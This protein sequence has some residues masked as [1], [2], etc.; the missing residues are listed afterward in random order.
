MCYSNLFVSVDALERGSLDQQV[1]LSDP[2]VVANT[3]HSCFEAAGGASQG[4]VPC[5]AA[6]RALCTAH[7]MLLAGLPSTCISEAR[8][9]SLLKRAGIYSPEDC[10]WGLKV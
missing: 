10:A 6:I 3:L 1:L 9:S 7:T 2:S 5:H 4:S 8:W